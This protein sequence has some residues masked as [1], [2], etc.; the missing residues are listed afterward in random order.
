MSTKHKVSAVIPK[1]TGY[2]TYV[3]AIYKS[4]V[5]VDEG[6]GWILHRNAEG[7]SKISRHDLEQMHVAL[8]DFGL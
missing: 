7:R 1:Q 5:D 6:D 2:R 8:L 4:C 3:D